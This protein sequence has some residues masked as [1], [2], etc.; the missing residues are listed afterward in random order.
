MFPGAGVRNVPVTWP[1]G[2]ALDP[3]TQVHSFPCAFAFGHGNPETSKAAQSATLNPIPRPRSSFEASR[4][5]VLWQNDNQ[6]LVESVHATDV[7]ELCTIV[8]STQVGPSPRLALLQALG[9]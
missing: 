8:A 6:P 3:P 9:G 1:T 4:S 7:D 2:P 5:V